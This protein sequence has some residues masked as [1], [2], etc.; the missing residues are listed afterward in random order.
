MSPCKAK[1][2]KLRN[3]NFI[4][5]LLASALAAHAGEGRGEE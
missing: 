4:A 2:A 3:V 1:G 5:F